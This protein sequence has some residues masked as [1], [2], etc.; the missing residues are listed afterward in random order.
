MSRSALTRTPSSPHIYLLKRNPNGSEQKCCTCPYQLRK[1][2]ARWITKTTLVRFDRSDIWHLQ[3]L[4]GVV[5]GGKAVFDVAHLKHRIQGH[6]PIADRLRKVWAVNLDVRVEMNDVDL[7]LTAFY[8]GPDDTVAVEIPGFRISQ[9]VRGVVRAVAVKQFISDKQSVR[10]NLAD[11]R[12]VL[13][14]LKLSG[15][16]RWLLF[17]ASK[18]N[19]DEAAEPD[20]EVIRS[21]YPSLQAIMNL[22]AKNCSAQVGETSE[23][24]R[25]CILYELAPGLTQLILN[26]SGVRYS[27]HELSIAPHDYLDS[28][29]MTISIHRNTDL[30][31]AHVFKPGC[32]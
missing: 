11:H 32:R 5:S 23:R 3:H 7:K 4:P 12:V 15:M 6:T 24:L 20:N 26:T 13:N 28:S 8:K 29:W 18:A 16:P 9:N 30:I 17:A 31:D 1:T 22:T 27:M 25:V 19:L 21:G 14:S 2:G 10:F